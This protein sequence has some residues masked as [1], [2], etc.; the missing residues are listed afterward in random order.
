MAKVHARAVIVSIG[1]ELVLGQSLD[2]NSRWLSEELLARGV[3]PVRHV[4]VEDDEAVIAGELVRSSGEADLVVVTGGLGPTADDLT[5]AALARAMGAV[6][7]ID[8]GAMAQV[9]GWYAAR[10]RVM[11]EVNRVQAMRPV[12][13]VCLENPNGTAPGV[14]AVVGEADVFCLPGPPREMRPM[15]ERFVAGALRPG[16]VVRTRLVRTFGLGESKVAEL[17]GELMDRSRNPLVGTTAQAGV[18]TVRMRWEGEGRQKDEGGRMKDEPAGPSAGT[19][20]APSEGPRGEREWDLDETERAVRERLGA[21]VVTP[22][23][24]DGDLG[25]AEVVVG[26]LKARGERLAV[27]ESCT[28]GLLGEKVTAVAGSSAVFCGGWITYTNAMKAVQAGVPEGYFPEVREGA[29]GAVSGEVARA[30]ALGGLERGVW[31][32]RGGVEGEGARSTPPRGG[33]GGVEHCLAITGIAGPD[34][35]SE[36]KPVGTVWICR[37]SGD[38]TVD[39]RRFLFAGGREAVREWAAVMA[40]GMLRLKLAGVDL[41]LVGEQERRGV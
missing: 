34:G 20:R 2:T 17:L 6:L 27:V 19:G 21:A 25:L 26:L 32:L 28:G 35:G 41:G 9:E 15:F 40:L 1:D 11:P 23:G 33:G 31:E 16:A 12:G 10:G 14:R 38:G 7:E 22:A 5:R 18:V 29:P 8:A 4:T 37:A 24:G 30:M 39:C 13:A 36:G 3:R